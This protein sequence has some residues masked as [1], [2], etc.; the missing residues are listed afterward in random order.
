VK[1]SL[2]GILSELPNNDRPID[3]EVTVVQLPVR[4]AEWQV[5]KKLL[6]LDREELH[7][8]VLATRVVRWV[9]ALSK[10]E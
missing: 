9:P 7:D 1:V 2:R 8:A 10:E 5:S 6:D 4:L 3:F